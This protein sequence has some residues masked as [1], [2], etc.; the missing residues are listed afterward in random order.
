MKKIIMLFSVLILS[1]AIRAQT[2]QYTHDSPAK[3]KT[4]GTM[5]G[6]T[7]VALGY[8]LPNGS[9][10]NAAHTTIGTITNGVV[11]N[12]TQ[13]VVGSV[14]PEGIVLDPQNVTLGYVLDDGVITDALGKLIGRAV[15]VNKTW[16]AVC[17][18]FY[19][20]N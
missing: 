4:D 14:T 5:E 2:I 3:I 9:I 20:V 18:F 12:A 10:K 17:F 19:K 7:G 15:G 11:K 8:V 13:V 6:T 16:A 1:T